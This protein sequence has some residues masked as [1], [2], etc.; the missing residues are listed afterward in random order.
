MN[1]AGQ[2]QRLLEQVANTLMRLFGDG[3]VS[4][5]PVRE[6]FFGEL[7]VPVLVGGDQR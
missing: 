2:N 5:P 4:D 7:S 1:R 3:L 6:Q